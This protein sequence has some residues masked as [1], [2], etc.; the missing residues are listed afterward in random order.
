MMSSA[1]C[2][3]VVACASLSLHVISGFGSEERAPLNEENQGL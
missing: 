2:P 1:P 3:D